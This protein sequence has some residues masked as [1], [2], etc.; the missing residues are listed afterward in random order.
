MF[1]VKV[2]ANYTMGS[3]S[4]SRQSLWRR[5]RYRDGPRRVR[6]LHALQFRCT[7]PGEDLI[8]FGTEYSCCHDLSLRL[9]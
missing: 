3:G 1:A 9:S 7:G 4:E 6:D 2:R 5:E 8:D